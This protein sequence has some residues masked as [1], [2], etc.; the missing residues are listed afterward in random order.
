MDYPKK[1]K[2]NL[3]HIFF[4]KSIRVLLPVFFFFFSSFSFYLFPHCNFQVCSLHHFFHFFR[5]THATIKTGES[6]SQ[7]FLS[8]SLSSFP[9]FYVRSLSPLSH[10][11]SS[12]CP[13]WH[14]VFG[15]GSYLEF[16][17]RWVFGDG[18]NL[19]FWLVL[20]FELRSILSFGGDA[21]LDFLLV[22]GVSLSLSLSLSLIRLWPWVFG[23]GVWF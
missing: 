23:C 6:I 15:G 8:F 2:K 13:L 12:L 21:D 17:W 20:G 3:R 22:F 7:Q 5:F 9:L 16:R 10:L 11:D 4:K 19:E 1:K 18:A 14:R